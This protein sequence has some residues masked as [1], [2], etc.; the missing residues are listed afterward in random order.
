MT[1]YTIIVIYYL[2]FHIPYKFPIIFHIIFP[3]IFHI[4]LNL[5]LPGLGGPGDGVDALPVV[6]EPADGG[7]GH[8]RVQDGQALLVHRNNRHLVSVVLV[9]RKL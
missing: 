4:I 6:D 7:Q 3:I 9:P 5:I 8:A 2:I 1:E